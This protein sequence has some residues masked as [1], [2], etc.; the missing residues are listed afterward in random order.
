MGKRKWHVLY[1]RPRR[2][3]K[4]AEYC[5]LLDLPYFLPLRE[6]TKIYQRRRVTVYKTIFPG[7]IFAA[8]D[9]AGRVNLLKTNNVVRILVPE[10]QRK[11][12]HE[13]AQIRKALS[14]DPTL[15]AAEALQ[16]GRMVRISG[17]PFAGVEGMI[18]TLKG[19]T[20]VRLNVEMIGQAV[21]LEVAREF[22]E[23][24]D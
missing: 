8:M 21:K 7:Y 14:V 12:L 9:E 18:E 19:T 3:K 17:G 23:L 10:S 11:L 6:E 16:K 1:L 24:I 4:T 13:L 15:G 20:A 2:E 22:L 5:E